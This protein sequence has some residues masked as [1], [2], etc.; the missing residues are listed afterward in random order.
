MSVSYE[1]YYISESKTGYNYTYMEKLRLDKK[2][3]TSFILKPKIFIDAV[4]QKINGSLGH[5][6]LCFS[7]E[8]SNSPSTSE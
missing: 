7:L 2:I 8:V 1:A 5:L 4:H 3:L 6:Y